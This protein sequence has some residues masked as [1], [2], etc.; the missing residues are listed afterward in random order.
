ME[1]VTESTTQLKLCRFVLSKDLQG[2][3]NTFGK[4]NAELTRQEFNDAWTRWLEHNQSIIKNEENELKKKGFTGNLDDKMYKSARYYFRKKPAEKK[5][6]KERRKYVALEREVIESIDN[7]IGEHHNNLGSPAKCYKNYMENNNTIVQEEY[8]R[9]QEDNK[10]SLS[11]CEE[12]IKKTYK[13]R[14]FQIHNLNQTHL[15]DNNGNS[16]TNEPNNI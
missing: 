8:K 15:L 3:I 7:H 2:S 14:Y 10:L 5:A 1:A 12:K 16:S 11:E 9:L 6:P 4:N 13:N